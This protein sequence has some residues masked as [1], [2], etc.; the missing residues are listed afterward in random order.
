[1]YDVTYRSTGLLITVMPYFTRIDKLFI[2]MLIDGAWMYADPVEDHRASGFMNQQVTVTWRLF[3]GR[4]YV[5]NLQALLPP[6]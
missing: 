3:R 5:T 4:R 2:A 1:M 6:S